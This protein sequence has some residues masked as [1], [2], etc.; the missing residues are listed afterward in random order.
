MTA[1][2]DGTDPRFA[3]LVTRLYARL[4]RYLASKVPAADAHDIVQ[5]TL[6]TLLQKIGP[7]VRE[8]ERFAFGIVRNK[9]LQHYRRRT[10]VEFDSQA[11]SV[12]QWTTTIGTRLALRSSFQSAM[13][14]L[15]EV[16]QSAIELRYGEGLS[17]EEVAEVLGVSLASAKRYLKAGLATLQST[18][19]PPQP[20]AAQDSGDPEDPAAFEALARRVR[21]DYNTDE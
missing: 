7:E 14:H 12:H 19:A 17:L 13:T 1:P 10:G 6:M 4:R 11:M 20:P 3:E 16:Q 5:D 18:L 21:E 2:T 15:N 8:P 9:L